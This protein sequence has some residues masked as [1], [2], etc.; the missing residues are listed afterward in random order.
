M[1]FARDEMI[2]SGGSL[3]KTDAVFV[4]E[5][6]SVQITVYTPSQSDVIAGPLCPPA[7]GHEYVNGP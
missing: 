6:T 3:I 5:F 4:H 2:N 1:S 7:P